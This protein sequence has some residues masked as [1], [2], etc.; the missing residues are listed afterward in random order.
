MK[1]NY[2]SEI[3]NDDINII[4]SLCCFFSL[5]FFRHK[6]KMYGNEFFQLFNCFIQDNYLN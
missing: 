4:I 2:P 5:I 1:Q 3:Y 6:F